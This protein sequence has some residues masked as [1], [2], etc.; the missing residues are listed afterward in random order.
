[1]GKKRDIKTT[2]VHSYYDLRTFSFRF[3]P[4]ARFDGF[5]NEPVVLLQRPP[6]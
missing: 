5:Y 2:F 4:E 3:L 6:Q 1:M